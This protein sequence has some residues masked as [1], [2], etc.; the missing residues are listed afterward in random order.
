MPL[1]NIYRLIK[2][3]PML[4][5]SEKHFLYLLITNNM[6]PSLTAMKKVLLF[7]FVCTIAFMSC[8]SS[9][10][11][12]IENDSIAEVMENEDD[13]N[14]TNDSEDNDNN[15]T[16]PLSLKLLSL[17]DS[18]T[19]G[20][21][22]CSTCRFPAQL[23]DSLTH[24]LGEATNID[25]SIIATSGWTTTDLISAINDIEPSSEYDIVTL[26]IG[27]NNQFLSLPFDLFES[28]FAELIIKAATAANGD[29]SKIIVLSIPDY[30]YTPFGQSWSDPQI[31]SEEID[32]YNA[33]IEA[34]CTEND[35][36]FINVTDISRDGLMNPTLVASDGLHL[37]ETAYALFAERLLPI[38][39]EKL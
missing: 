33:F 18:Y 17:G 38:V 14:D 32:M 5:N 9:D 35:I 25:L 30:A 12:S 19:I 21:S 24:N 23:K 31:T 8:N 16:D 22:V 34:Y 27:V 36:S 37:S 13:E 6:P 28:E 11:T 20:S 2:S 15:D 4:L 1:N 7:I 29:T 39:L 3:I 10:E 26:L